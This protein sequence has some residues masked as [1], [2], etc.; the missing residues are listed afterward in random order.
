[1][2][3]YR[4]SYHAG[5]HADVLKHATVA[6]LV[7]ALKKKE[8]PFAYV[9][10]HAGAGRY[11]LR[12]EQ[13]QKTG[14]YLEGIARL[15]QEPAAPAALGS[16]LEAVRALNSGGELVFY[17]GSPRVVRHSL[18]PQD[19][20]SLME[21][22]NNEYPVLKQEFAGDRQV[23]VHHR[24]GYEGLNAL[25]P[26]K[27]KRGLVL[28]DP[29]YEVKS[30]Y[31]QVVTS[32]ATAVKRWSNGIYAVWYPLLASAQTEAFMAQFRATGLRKLLRAEITVR[33]EGI[34]MY[35]SGML[36]LNPP[37]HLDS[38]LQELLPW[39]VERLAPGVGQARVDWLVPE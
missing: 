6:L 8:G 39:V 4:H 11:D 25:L 17:P 27:E 13:A 30:E 22:H 38:Q 31:G 23:A 32:L 2:L 1:M 9:E 10:T 7:E 35:G 36:V 20:M 33:G 37:W 24:D 14:E 29:S 28:I 3:S 26:P 21:L 12:S 34:G 5:N 19:R 15:W 18:R 16:Y